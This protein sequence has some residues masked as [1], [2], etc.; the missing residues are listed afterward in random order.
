MKSWMISLEL[1][2]LM[3]LGAFGCSNP[4]HGSHAD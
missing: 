3:L 4:L 1:L 2:A